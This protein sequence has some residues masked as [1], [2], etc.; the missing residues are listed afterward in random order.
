[1]TDDV[2]AVGGFKPEAMCSCGMSNT[3]CA[4]WEMCQSGVV[5]VCKHLYA[6][7]YLRPQL[8]EHQL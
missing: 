5:A 1:M 4:S 2:P 6:I 3:V 8:P 7:E